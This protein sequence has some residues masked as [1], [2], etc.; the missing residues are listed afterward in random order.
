MINVPGGLVLLSHII[1]GLTHNG[2]ASGVNIHSRGFLKC[3]LLRSQNPGGLEK[4]P[5]E[6]HGGDED[7]PFDQV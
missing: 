4:R 5:L 2:E 3:P 6:V 1:S 7:L